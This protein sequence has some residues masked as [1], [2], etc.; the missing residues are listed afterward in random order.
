MHETFSIDTNVSI[1]QVDLVKTVLQ[2]RFLLSR[3][4]LKTCNKSKLTQIIYAYTVIW[5]GY[6]CSVC[7]CVCVLFFFFFKT[8]GS[9]KT[10]NILKYFSSITF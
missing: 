8:L 6:Q 7:V 2:S 1:Q 4:T 9:V 3:G 5:V 10:L